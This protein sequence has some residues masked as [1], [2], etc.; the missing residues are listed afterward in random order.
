[1]EQLTFKIER[2]PNSNQR[3]YEIYVGYK[4]GLSEEVKFVRLMKEATVSEFEKY[5]KIITED[6]TLAFTL[7]HTFVED[8]FTKVARDEKLSTKK[9]VDWLYDELGNQIKRP[10]ANPTLKPLKI[11]MP[12]V[13]NKKE[14]EEVKKSIKS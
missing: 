10:F 5:Y 2:L 1:M 11:Q 4:L 7:F 6:T 3:V 13:W 14:T 12:S 8:I 9:E